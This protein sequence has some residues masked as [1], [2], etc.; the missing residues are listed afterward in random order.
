MREHVKSAF[1]VASLQYDF[2]QL[3]KS[4]WKKTIG[5]T[6]ML[7]FL[8]WKGEKK[9]KTKQTNHPNQETH[10]PKPA[11]QC[12]L[13]PNGQRVHGEDLVC[14][15]SLSLQQSLPEARQAPDHGCEQTPRPDWR[16]GVSIREKKD[17]EVRGFDPMNSFHLPSVPSQKQ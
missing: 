2:G 10:P 4:P 17:I 1:P 16:G 3:S 11:R 12:L 5:E 13:L 7:F 14:L 8:N 15:K 6:R 9:K